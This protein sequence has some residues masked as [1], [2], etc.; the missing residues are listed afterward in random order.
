[1][2]YVH[3]LSTHLYPF[4]VR[5]GGWGLGGWFFFINN[6]LKSITK[7][8]IVFCTQQAIMWMRGHVVLTE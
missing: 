5:D 6:Q 3:V 1:M 7:F 2:L 4:L 8:D